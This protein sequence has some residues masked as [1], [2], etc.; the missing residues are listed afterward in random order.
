MLH[1]EV[2]HLSGIHLFIQGEI[3]LI[4]LCWGRCWCKTVAAVFLNQ[5]VGYLSPQRMLCLCSVLASML[6]LG[7][8]PWLLRLKLNPTEIT[9]ISFPLSFHFK[10]K[11]IL[12]IFQDPFLCSPGN[13]KLNVVRFLHKTQ[14]FR[15]ST[16]YFKIMIKS[17]FWQQKC[18]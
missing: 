18:C 3:F 12:D 15:R 11:I 2:L 13:Q 4:K 1:I 9:S 16:K 6:T 5:G 14:E 10:K 8:M 7:A 17:D